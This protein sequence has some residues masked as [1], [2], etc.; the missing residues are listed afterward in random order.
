MEAINKNEEN[1]FFDVVKSLIYSSIGI[2]VFFI[3]ININGKALTTIYHIAEFIQI[4]GEKSLLVIYSIIIVFNVIKEIKYS[5]NHK[6]NIIQ[7]STVI[8]ILSM[9]I[10]I[11]VFYNQNQ[12]IKMD[13]NSALILQEVVLEA[14]VIVS[15]SAIF[16]PL[17]T[18]YGLL[19]VTESYFNKAMKKNFKI[20]GKSIINIA[21]YM[22]A[23]I[24][25]GIFMTNRLYKQ[26]KLRQNEVFIIFMYFPIASIPVIN[27]ICEE[28][29]INKI[30]TILMSII[31]MLICN[32]IMVRIYPA[33]NKKKSYYQ[34]SNYKECNF[35]KDKRFIRALDSNIK[36]R[37]NENIFKRIIDSEKECISI[38]ITLIPYVTLALSLIYIIIN[39]LNLY[40][41]YESMLNPLY[42]LC[43]YNN[44][45]EISIFLSR[46][47]IDNIL[48][49]ENLP[50]I[51]SLN[52]YII[53]IIAIVGNVNLLNKYIAV[54]S[55]NLP[56]K[57]TEIISSYIIRIIVILILYSIGYHIIIGYLK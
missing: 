20:S 34:K 50:N 16:M 4:K 23:G 44:T 8:K 45:N 3:P 9:F 46:G 32:F 17:I 31:I 14:L 57:N 12:F 54:K 10:L 2:F 6:D 39:E 18:D 37:S 43:K 48:S 30:L 51:V 35:K 26:G 7:I 28:F 42:N 56:I 5:Q 29:N 22:S 52:T 38:Q 25:S 47:I 24:Y 41:L 1:I 33:K 53:A 13:D 55:F 27:Y 19:E 15:I 40:I 49:I 36:N 21:L 11:V